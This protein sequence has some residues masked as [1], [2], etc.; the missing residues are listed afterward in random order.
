MFR[1]KA[2]RFLYIRRTST[3][4]YF[5]TKK[6]PACLKGECLRVG[7]RDPKHRMRR[8]DQTFPAP[9]TCY[10]ALLTNLMSDFLPFSSLPVDLNDAFAHEVLTRLYCLEH[11][12]DKAHKEKEES[13]SLV[14]LS[15]LYSWVR[16]TVLNKA[17]T[18]TPMTGELVI[19]DWY[20]EGVLDRYLPSAMNYVAL[21][22][23][24]VY[25]K[26]RDEVESNFVKFEAYAL[27][28]LKL[29]LRAIF[30]GIYT[31]HKTLQIT[32][33][34][35]PRQIDTRAGLAQLSLF[36]ETARDEK[37]PD[38]VVGADR[39]QVA[40]MMHLLQKYLVYGEEIATRKNEFIAHARKRVVCKTTLR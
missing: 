24:K 3:L 34:Q 33:H 6:L 30:K 26:Y 35:P 7:Q 32:Y 36:L 21:G 17:V 25:H 39:G 2:S 31:C 28:A 20:A 5:E 38:R 8:C 10:H 40:R 12:R 23:S 16:D 13:Q 18:D 29:D 1:A 11:D 22:K 19:V 27:D 15:D 37:W 4:C 9:R 14:F